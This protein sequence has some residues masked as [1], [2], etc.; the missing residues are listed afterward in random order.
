MAEKMTKSERSELGQL[1][2]KRERVM[3]AAAME[4]SAAM[5][6]EFDTQLTA[7]Y[8]FD[9]DEV[10]A[11]ANA[12]ADKAVEAANAEI[13]ARCEVLGIPKDFAPSLVFGWRE[14]GQNAV[15]ARRTELRQMARSRI[16]KIE[17]EA[18]TKIERMSLEAQTEVIANGLQ[19]KAALDFLEKM[20][21]LE[22]LMPALDANELKQINDGQQKSTNW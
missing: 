7:I 18:I 14:R 4:R 19:S 11:K 9:D 22:S 8:S 20:P 12:E 3:K 15:K 10:W 2:R 1:I 21:T 6:A 17:K 13:A 5:L 16:A